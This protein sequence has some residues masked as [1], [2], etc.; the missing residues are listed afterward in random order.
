MVYVHLQVFTFSDSYGP[1]W[2]AATFL[3]VVRYKKHATCHDHLKTMYQTVLSSVYR[4]FTRLS[5]TV[6]RPQTVVTGYSPIVGANST[7]VQITLAGE[8]A[9]ILADVYAINGTTGDTVYNVTAADVNGSWPLRVVGG[10]L[11]LVLPPMQ[12]HAY[13]WIV[14][15]T[16]YSVPTVTSTPASVAETFAVPQGF[17]NPKADIGDSSAI[18]WVL[19]GNCTTPDAGSVNGAHAVLESANRGDANPC[20]FANSSC[21]VQR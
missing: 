21:L 20:S 17:V 4:V 15:I 8:Y 7:V 10:Q 16:R 13:T 2:Y 12:W 3:S 18:V 19:Y 6:T 1:G 14:V 9:Q 5:W 11:L